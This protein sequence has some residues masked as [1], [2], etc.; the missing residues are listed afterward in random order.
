MTPYYTMGCFYYIKL[1]TGGGVYY[2]VQ[3]LL[4]NESHGR[5]YAEKEEH[6]LEEDI[7]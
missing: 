5:P 2:Q 4:V 7:L 3:R 6:I 1:H